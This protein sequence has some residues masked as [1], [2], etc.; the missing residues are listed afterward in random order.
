MGT[1]AGALACAAALT[2]VPLPS[3]AQ[4]G[5]PAC[6]PGGPAVTYNGS[7]TTANAKTYMVRPFGVA[8]GTTRVE[9]TYGWADIG[10]LPSTPLTQTVFD[11][12][13]WDEDGYRAVDGFRGWSGSR[14]G[15]VTS[16]QE[17]V[18]VQQDVAARG[19]RPGVIEPGTWWVD[20]GVAAVAPLGATWHV[21][22]TCSAPAVG[23]PFVADP[24][25]PDHV[26]AAEP[27]WHHGDFHFHGFH[28]N[29]RAPSWEDTLAYAR[30]VGLDI[31]AVT[32][33]VTTQ[34]WGEL[35]PVQ[36]ANPD[37]LVV[38][39]REV[40]TYFGHATVFGETPGVV[41]YRHGF[42]DVSLRGIQEASVADG[43]LFGVAHP[44]TFPGPIFASFCRGCAFELGNTIDW[45][46]VTT[47]EVLTGPVLV[48]TSELGLP[49]VPLHIQN[50]FTV[51]AINEWE[52][53]L[54]RGYR[55]T[56]VSGSDSK[57][58]EGEARR[59]WGTSATAVYTEG[60]S[61]AG[62]ADALRAGHAYVRARGVHASPA[63]ELRAVTPDG[64]EGMFGDSL[65]ADRADVTVT[66]TG[67]QGQVLAIT[68]DGFLG[69]LPV[70]ITSDPFTHTF[71]ATRAGGSGPLGTFWRVDTFDLQSLTTIGNPIFLTGPAPAPEVAAPAAP[72]VPAAAASPESS[73]SVTATAERAARGTLPATGGQQWRS[74]AV[75]LLAVGVV[76]RAVHRRGVSR[77]PGRRAS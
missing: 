8:P 31:V 26:A 61:Q 20:I 35:G 68:R 15:R 41:D 25:D 50:P 70:L 14:A 74:A 19:Y 40:I 64:Q 11:L 67:G 24:V 46:K 36:R 73:G 60:L 58:V 7:V 1:L 32:D 72:I 53:L 76:L 45:S 62:L 22:V 3:P 18:F 63:L 69:A 49:A 65:A 44:T 17:P 23:P 5:P 21:E 54:K 9:V 48:G 10:G 77:P 12:G 4:G 29:P 42:E 30:S 52:S 43:A 38:P 6:A 56:A 2:L 13:L 34:H 66:V 16:G 37:V 33:Y 39:S 71:T 28:S 57:G 75:G 51:P 27:G 47:I 59:M 55:I